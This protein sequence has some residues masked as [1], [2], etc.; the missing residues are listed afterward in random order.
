MRKLIVLFC[1]L[2]PLLAYAS[3]GMQ[4]VGWGGV[5]AAVNECE[6][7][8]ICQNFEGAGYDNSETW[9]E[10][11]TTINEDYETVV[12]RGSQS[13]LLDNAAAGNPIVTSP[14]F[15]SATVWVFFRFRFPGALPAG[16][17]SF[18]AI[19]GNNPGDPLTL[20]LISYQAS[21]TGIRVYTDSVNLDSGA[22]SADTT[23]YCWIRYTAGSGANATV[24]LYLDTDN[25]RPAATATTTSGTRTQN[26]TF[27][28]AFGP[29]G[30]DIV[31]DQ[32]LIDDA[33]ITD[34]QS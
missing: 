7:K 14:T 20:V 31:I 18:A 26:A 2:L 1:C 13:L 30:C 27:F 24:T 28:R 32:I 16:N 11:G 8:L 25:T 5:P 17:A 33:E 6:G 3:S 21:I 9:S 12:L 22:I 4:P 10:S 23:Y 29:T 34:V 19:Y 15:S